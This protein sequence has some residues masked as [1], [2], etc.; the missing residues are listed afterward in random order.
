MDQDIWGSISLQDMQVYHFSLGDLYVWLVHRNE[1]V[2]IAHCYSNEIKG[3]LKEDAPPA[4]V[5]WSR[6][7]NKVVSSEVEIMPVFPDLPLIVHSEYTLK[8]SSDTRIQIFT[9]IPI[10]I[11]ISL[12]KNDY[13]LI[14]L[15]TIKLSRTWFGSPVEGELC[16]HA[17][18]KARRD[19]SQVERKPYLVS[20][21]ILISNKSEEELNFHNFCLRVERL[22]IYQHEDELWADETQIIYQGE[23]LNSDVIMTGKLPKGIEKKQLLSKPRKQIQKSLATRTFKRIFEDT[24]TFG[25]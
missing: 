19:L 21:P 3:E 4:D 8:V 1:E 17:T 14:E 15:P 12:K 5:E 24:L 18:T 9:R 2:W 16:Y 6:W 10:W 11:K 13:K 25:R 7:A 22:S 20:C 23:D